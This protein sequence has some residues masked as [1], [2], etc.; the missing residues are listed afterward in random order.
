MQC[1]GCAT[2]SGCKFRLMRVWR[3]PAS[4]MQGSPDRP[5]CAIVSVLPYCI[6][7]AFL[8]VF[9]APLFLSSGAW[10]VLAALETSWTWSRGYPPL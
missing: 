1:A 4:H 10:P 5:P 9:R 6:T 3:D 8:F 2:C 7:H